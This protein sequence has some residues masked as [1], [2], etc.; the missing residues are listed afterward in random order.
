MVAVKRLDTEIKEGDGEFRT[1]MRAIGRTHHRNLIRLL[2]FC[3][4]GSHRLLV[5]EYMSNGLLANLLFKTE[6]RPNWNN[7]MRIAMEIAKASL[8]LHDDYIN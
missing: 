8:Y 5:F 3:V 6:N 4:E 7:M 2:S 1:E